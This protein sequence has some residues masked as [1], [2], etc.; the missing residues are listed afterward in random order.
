M[1]FLY[2]TTKGPFAFTFGQGVAVCLT[3][4]EGDRQFVRNVATDIF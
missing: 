4:I 2:L 1:H 3:I